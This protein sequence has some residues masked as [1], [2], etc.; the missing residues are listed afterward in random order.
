LTS[1]VSWWIDER[2]STREK[3]EVMMKYLIII[4]ILLITVSVLSTVG[5]I[6]ILYGA[7]IIGVAGIVTILWVGALT[8]REME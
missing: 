2:K 7:L 3:E 8:I 6:N 5:L 1:I 4:V